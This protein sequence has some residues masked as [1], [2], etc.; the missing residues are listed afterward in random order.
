MPA[1]EQSGRSLDWRSSIRE[2]IGVQI[3]SPAYM[4]EDTDRG[5]EGQSV[6]TGPKPRFESSLKERLLGRNTDASRGYK[7]GFSSVRRILRDMKEN[8]FE[9]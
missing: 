6:G 1:V 3:P 5:F 9:G 7:G 2:G 8:L 4:T